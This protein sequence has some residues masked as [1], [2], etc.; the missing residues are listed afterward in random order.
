[1]SRLAFLNAL[2]RADRRTPSCGPATSIVSMELMDCL[3]V[4]FPEAHLDAQKMAAL[5]EAA[6][7]TTDTTS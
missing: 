7:P 4:S 1:M 3:S 5:A 6:T 2:R